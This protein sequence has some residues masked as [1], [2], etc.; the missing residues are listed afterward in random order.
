MAQT[1]IIQV[2]AIPSNSTPQVIS[3]TSRKSLGQPGDYTVIDGRQ[4]RITKTRHAGTYKYFHEIIPIRP[5]LHVH[6]FGSSGRCE[7]GVGSPLYYDN[8][9]DTLKP[10]NPNQPPLLTARET[11]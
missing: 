7:C 6:H 1:N 8:A 10:H 4:Y 9:T 2:K 3:I 5:Q 11:A